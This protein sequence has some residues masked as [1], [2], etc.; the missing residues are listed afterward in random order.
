M[1][2]RDFRSANVQRCEEVFHPLDDWSAADWAT[3]MM[4]EGGEA[5]NLVK[6]LR[7]G[8]FD[9]APEVG[10]AK[11][12]DE[13][14]DLVTYADLLAARLGIDLS[15][16]IVEKFNRVSWRTGSRVTISDAPP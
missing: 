7:R 2:L 3:A 12:A 9:S 14:A 15:A 10:I 1:N 16:A 13:L 4:G 6:K 5:C 11:I 8:D